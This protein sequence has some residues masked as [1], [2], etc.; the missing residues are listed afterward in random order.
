MSVK[1]L[2]GLKF[3]KLTVES[4]AES[5][6]GH[7]YWLCICEC[8]GS[9]IVRGSHLLSG[10]VRSCGCIVARKTHGGTGTRLWNIWIQMRQRCSYQNAPNYHR[11][12]G[13]GI[14]VCEEW[15]N[16]FEAFRN[17]ALANGYRDDLTIDRKD[18][19][20]HYCPENCRWTTR[21]VQSNNTKRNRVL[22]LNGEEHTLS[23]WAEALSINPG[24][25]SSRVNRQHWSDE[26]ALST[27]IDEAK[28]NRKVKEENIHVE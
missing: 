7:L 3:G 20:G 28:R 25:L 2:A 5:R 4:V 1:N 26:K 10:N 9:K 17:W 21:K 18:N 8:G 24:T 22:T 27:P 6:N 12:G 23:E 16:S 11:Y 13:R 14:A 15:E 19:D